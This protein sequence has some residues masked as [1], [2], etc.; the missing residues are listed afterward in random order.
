MKIAKMQPIN[1]DAKPSSREKVLFG[2]AL[3]GVLIVISNYIW[4]PQ[5]KV[6]G[7]IK[8]EIANL[9]QQVDAT[10]TLIQ[11]TDTQL[12][13]LSQ[14]PQGSAQLD[15]QMNEMLN[16]RVVDPTDEANT[17]M[18]LLSS[19]QNTR[20]VDIKNISL[21]T[22]T[23]GKDY[24]TIPIT[25]EVNGRFSGIQNYIEMIEK[26]PRPLVV[27]AI[28]MKTSPEAAGVLVTTLKLDLLILK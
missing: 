20:R 10:K 1:L 4:A 23:E 26:L 2:F 3:I 17:T 6:T 15:T 21:G 18:D 7:G 27:R 24:N 19:R 14:A 16:R 8:Q 28:D 5:S 9:D 13:Q 22:Q 12:Q 11:A 25:V